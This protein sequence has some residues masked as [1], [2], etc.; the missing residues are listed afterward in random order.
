MRG[1]KLKLLALGLAIAAI[2]LAVGGVA[3]NHTVKE[4]GDLRFRYNESLCAHAGVNPFK[5][6]NHDA[7]LAEFKGMHRPDKEYDEDGAKL[8]VHAYPPWHMVYTWFYGWLPFPWV[9][10]IMY[11]IS[12][13]ALTGLFAILRGCEAGDGDAHR[14]YLYWAWIAVW[15]LPPMINCLMWGQYGIMCAGLLAVL[16]LGIKR[17]A[18][19]VAGV[20]WGLMMIK[21]QMAA[22]FFFPLL[23][24]KKYKAI[25]VAV[26][27]SAAA[28]IVL[29]CHYGESPIALILQVP[30]IGAP[31]DT[32]VIYPHL[33]PAI[34]RIVK[35]GWLVVCIGLCGWLSWKVKDAE[36][37]ICRF[38]PAALIF[39]YWMYSQWH[40]QVVTWPLV[41]VM[42]GFIWRG[43]NSENRHVRWG[44]T[45]SVSLTILMG[46]FSA[47]W[48]TLVGL[49]V[50]NPAGRGWIY[51][52]FNLPMTAL[53]FTLGC[54]VLSF[55]QKRT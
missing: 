33:P 45:I 19:V 14:R 54:L 23:F 17:D 37:Y 3:R 26:A 53:H 16:I 55:A 50:F 48:S 49:E 52:I 5:I 8:V 1:S 6:W 31:Y 51:Q 18:Q 40:D 12:G 32:S 44:I 47:T 10:G 22:L 20:A 27:M 24:A 43:L 28:T 46:L 13:L 41:V 21:P 30:Q 35:A 25:L 15:L 29:A 38:A 36:S 39:P 34:A 2:A 42:A 4:P 11:F 7:T 9:V